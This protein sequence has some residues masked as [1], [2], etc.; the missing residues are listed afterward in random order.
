MRSDG[1][2]I[3]LLVA[4][5]GMGFGAA[6]HAEAA[7]SAVPLQGMAVTANTGEKPQSKLWFHD[8]RWWTVLPETTGTTLWRLDDTRWT[9]A[10]HL[11]DA[12][13]THA[14]AR[15]A[16][17]L[18]HV[19]LFETGRCELVSLAY[20][21]AAQ[22]YRFWPERPSGAA[23]SL[24]PR[25]ET[26]TIDVDSSG[27]LWLASDGETEITVRWSA[28]PYS[29]WSAP[30]VLATGVAGDDICVVT[31]FPNGGTG[32]LWSNQQTRRFGFRFHPGDAAPT[33]WLPDELPGAASALPV[34]GGM[35]DDHMNCAV[36]P[37]GTL[38]AAVKTSYDT[39]GYPLIGLL[40]RRPSGTWDGLYRVDDDG[41]RPI[42]LLNEKKD[43]LLVAYRLG[44]AI[45]YRE[46]PRNAIA[47]GSRHTLMEKDGERLNNVTS[48][49]D[50]FSGEIVFLASTDSAAEGVRLTLP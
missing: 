36:A 7:V 29:A 15:R 10:L 27:R 9:P 4:A 43:A 26:A 20:D 19:L 42:A 30:L 2:V 17:G 18:T 45:V 11:S 8:G 25:A 1:F 21:D 39:E 33:D 13:A 12:T 40:L 38:Y 24:D 44:D 31:A 23:I 37:D 14:D 5:I 28:P 32:V 47:F 50:R 3:G 34:G 22:T 16:D 49:K 46:S 48:T 41:T 35:A 6:A